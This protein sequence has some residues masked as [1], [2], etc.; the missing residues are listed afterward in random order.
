MRNAET[1]LQAEV[2]EDSLAVDKFLSH[3][4]GGG[5]HG[6]TSVL[7]LLG[8]D[9]LK[10]DRVRGLE[11]EGTVYERESG[12]AVRCVCVCMCARV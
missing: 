5:E 4:T 1:H 3:E 9:Q 7:E 8:L 6:E 11:A 2:L 10:L 12:K